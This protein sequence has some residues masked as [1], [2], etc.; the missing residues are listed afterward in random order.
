MKELTMREVE[1]VSGGCG[2]LCV[3]VSIGIG[4]AIA[5]YTRK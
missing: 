4:I 5:Y 2:G 3:A 1:E